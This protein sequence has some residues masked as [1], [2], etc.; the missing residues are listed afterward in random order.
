MRTLIVA[1]AAYHANLRQRACAL[2]GLRAF[3]SILRPSADTHEC[4]RCD[5]CRK[6]YRTSHGHDFSPIDVIRERL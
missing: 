1:A 5:D 6:Q 2:R 3:G 4:A